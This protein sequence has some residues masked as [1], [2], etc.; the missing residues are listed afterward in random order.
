MSRR[1]DAMP[2]RSRILIQSENTLGQM[3]RVSWPLRVLCGGMCVSVY[4]YVRV[5]VSHDNVACTHPVC[6]CLCVYCLCACVYDWV[7]DCVDACFCVCVF[8]YVCACV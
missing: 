5:F 8:N 6:E 3:L 1:G 4:V 7:S 2:M